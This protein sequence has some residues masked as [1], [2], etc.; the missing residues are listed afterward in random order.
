MYECKE[1][2]KLWADYE[3]QEPA[4]GDGSLQKYM[5]RLTQRQLKTII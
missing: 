3:V 4:V 5:P 1:F 2:A